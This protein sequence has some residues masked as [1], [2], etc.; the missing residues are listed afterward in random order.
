MIPRT[1]FWFFVGLFAAM[2]CSRMCEAAGKPRIVA[3]ATSKQGGAIFQVKNPLRKRIRFR[4]ECGDAYSLGWLEMGPRRSVRVD[5]SAVE[6]VDT[7]DCR[8][9]WKVRK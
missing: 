4:F 7:R 9:I 1:L 3:A 2:M 8:L 6:P 5:V